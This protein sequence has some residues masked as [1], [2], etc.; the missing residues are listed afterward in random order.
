MLILHWE[1]ARV[2]FFDISRDVVEAPWHRSNVS[3]ADSDSFGRQE[4]RCF[5]ENSNT[6]PGCKSSVY[7]HATQYEVVKPERVAG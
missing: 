1:F 5:H 4:V 3:V 7:G 2:D 6:L